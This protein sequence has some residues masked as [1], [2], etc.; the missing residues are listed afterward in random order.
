MA[1]KIVASGELSQKTESST[2]NFRLKSKKD[3]LILA[4]LFKS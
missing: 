4:G 2:E 3:P 1:R